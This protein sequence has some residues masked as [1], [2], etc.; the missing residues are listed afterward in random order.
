MLR[1]SLIALAAVALA[2]GC[3]ESRPSGPDRDPPRITLTL[4]DGS[5][6]PSFSTDEG[7]APPV[8][9]CGTARRFPAT[10]SVAVNDPGGINF[11]D[12]R[13]FPSEL[14]PASV[15]VGPDA[16]ATSYEITRDG[17]T[18]VLRITGASPR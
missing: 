16:P 7:S 8:D 4:L 6:T 13:V 10:V 11:V 1:H 2:A 18:D 17:P 14:I 3:V 9:A 5:G 15:T 12:I